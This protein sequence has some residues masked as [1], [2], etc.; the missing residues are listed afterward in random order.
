MKR[1][2]KTA[3]EILKN[4]KFERENPLNLQE[5]IENDSS[6]INEFLSLGF[7]K[8]EVDRYLIPLSEYQASKRICASCKNVNDCLSSIKHYRYFLNVEDDGSLGLSLGLCEKAK[9]LFL[10]EHNFLVRDFPS[11]WIS[12][13]DKEPFTRNRLLSSNS[14]MKLTKEK[15]FLILQG[16]MG[17][18]KT[19]QAALLS[20]YAVRQGEK[21][22]FLSAPKR[23]EEMIKL[24]SNFRDT[25]AFDD[26]FEEWRSVSLLVLDDFGAEYKTAKLRDLLLLP[27]LESRRR[28][29]KKTIFTTRDSINVIANEYGQIQYG[30]RQGTRLKECIEAG[31]SKIVSLSPSIAK[32]LVK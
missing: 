14:Y 23:L 32:K 30:K 17:V 19:F 29:G 20:L 1:G 2:E 25:Q 12:L 9:G 10:S 5:E 18:G 31:T 13:Y 24:A 15:P 28:E 26:K 3:L 6:L 8:E 22:A 7:L 16:E 27:L 4:Q 21:V 11:E